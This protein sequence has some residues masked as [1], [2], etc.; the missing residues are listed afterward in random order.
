MGYS[1]FSKAQ[2]PW[3]AANTHSKKKNG[4]D[5]TV[6]ELCKENRKRE[7]AG[8]PPLTYGKYVAQKEGNE[9][10]PRSGLPANI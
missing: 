8:L 4:L 5:M 1:D 9:K 6:H 7:K 2:K 10:M 3:D